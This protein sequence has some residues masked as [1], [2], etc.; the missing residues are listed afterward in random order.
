MRAGLFVLMP[1][2]AACGPKLPADRRYARD[3]AVAVDEGDERC[4]ASREPDDVIERCKRL[5]A[6]VKPILLE[7]DRDAG[8][9]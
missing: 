5:R 2:V 4:A 8:A 7:A 1:L 3:V 9:P 6:S